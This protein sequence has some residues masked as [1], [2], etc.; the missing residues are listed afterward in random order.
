MVEGS[1]GR[2]WL[3]EPGLPVSAEAEVTEEH[4]RKL[5]LQFFV[6]KR[7]ASI[8]P[9]FGEDALFEGECDQLPAE[10]NRPFRVGMLDLVGVPSSCTSAPSRRLNALFFHIRFYGAIEKALKD[11]AQQSVLVRE[12]PV[13]AGG[14]DA[15]AP[16][17]SRESERGRATSDSLVAD[18]VT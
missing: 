13:D 2:A 7:S 10:M 16:R 18:F 14:R 15:G 3:A 6:R 12:T 17:H 11:L 4:A 5:V 9:A 8:F 1:R